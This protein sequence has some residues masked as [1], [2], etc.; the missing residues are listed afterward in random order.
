MDHDLVI[1]VCNDT[2]TIVNTASTIAAADAAPILGTA[3]P[4]KALL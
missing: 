4:G 1:R 2:N 3:E